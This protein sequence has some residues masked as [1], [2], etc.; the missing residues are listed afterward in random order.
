MSDRNPLGGVLPRVV[1]RTDV[2]ET[3]I[4]ERIEKIEGEV[5]ADAYV[6]A[7]MSSPEILERIAELENCLQRI[8]NEALALGDIDKHRKL[9]DAAEEAGRVLKNRLEVENLT[10]RVKNRIRDRLEPFK[11]ELRMIDP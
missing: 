7:L 6:K 4:V 3:A 8:A 10:A 2:D 9:R 1:H 5:A 11:N